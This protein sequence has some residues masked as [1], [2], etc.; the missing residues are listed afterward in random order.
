MT[1]RYASEVNVASAATYEG[2]ELNCFASLSVC[3]SLTDGQEHIYVSPIPLHDL[4]I[5]ARLHPRI[6]LTVRIEGIERLWEVILTSTLQAHAH[7]HVHALTSRYAWLLWYPHLELHDMCSVRMLE[8][9][10]RLSV[11]SVSVH[12]H[13]RMSCTFRYGGLV[14]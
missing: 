14:C 9:R 2:A 10:D 11:P 5:D 8:K 4:S 13:V 12:R 6:H 3:L 7:I 1:D